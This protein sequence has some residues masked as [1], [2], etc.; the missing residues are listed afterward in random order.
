M[1]LSV[2]LKEI[3]VVITDGGTPQDKIDQLETM[4]LDVIVA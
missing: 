4:G 3:D 2:P 1:C